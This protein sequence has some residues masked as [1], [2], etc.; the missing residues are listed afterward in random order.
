MQRRS[1][2]AASAAGLALPSVVR[3]QSATT[4]NFIPQID[5]TFLD[6]HFTPANVTRVHGFMVYDTLF[7]EDGK[8]GTSDQMLAGHKIED[9]GKLWTLTLRDGLWFHDGTPVLA[10]DCVASIKRWSR[11]D[12]I[13][14]AMMAATDDLSAKDD[15]TIV[16]RL[17]KPFPLL[18]YAL[19]KA[20]S[21]MCGIMPARIAETDPF[22]QVTEIIGSGPF[23]FVTA[24]RVQGARNVYAKFDK[25]VPRQGGT[26]S[27]TG[28]PKVVH[29]DRVVWTTMPDNSTKANSLLA[30]EQEWWENPSYDLL[31]LLKR[32]RNV[33]LQVLDPMGGVLMVR[34]NMLQPPFNNVAI[35]RALLEAIDQTEFM[36][37][38]V[39]EA[40]EYIRKPYGVFPIG[41]PMASEAGMEALTGP[42]DIAKVREKIKAAGY[43]G[44]KAVLIVPTD[45][46]NLK[47]TADVWADLLKRVGIN[48]DYVATDWGQMLTRRNNKGPVDQGGWSCFTTGWSGSSVDTPAG[49]PPLRGNGDQKAAWPGWYVSPEMERMR[50]AW[51]E[52]P[53]LAAQQ[54]ICADMQRLAF[55]EV[56]FWPLG[57]SLA[58]TAYRKTL[59]GVVDGFAVFWN[60]RRA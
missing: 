16:F 50:G 29:F 28:G 37:A 32:D 55:Q 40:E 1:F 47:A 24:E 17:K 8:G 21:P 15:K 42:R 36:Q 52:A 31:P 35:R 19:G 54:K 2:L 38:V 20:A 13:G 26:P 25:Y 49:H 57:Q 6:P 44:E 30:G 39:G 7:G 3:A 45:Y 51:F 9:A 53:D 56:P 14:E 33:A 11:R 43:A 18:P 4:L 41:S 23:R 12:P 34:G 48:V 10:R 58:P 60:V 59:T 27:W 46:A 22:K 5:L